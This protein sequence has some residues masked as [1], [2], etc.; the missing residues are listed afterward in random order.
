[1][2][3]AFQIFAA[4]VS[5]HRWKTLNPVHKVSSVRDLNSFLNLF[6]VFFGGNQTVEATTCTSQRVVRPRIENKTVSLVKSNW[7]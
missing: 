1:M 2:Q 6:E 3:I 7:E 5:V 4:D